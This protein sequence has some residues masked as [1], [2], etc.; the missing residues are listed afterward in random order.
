[1]TAK[2]MNA[3]TIQSMQNSSK[4]YSDKPLSQRAALKLAGV[5]SQLT[6]HSVENSACIMPVLPNTKPPALWP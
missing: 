2:S 3:N 1:M 6:S 4:L 5:L